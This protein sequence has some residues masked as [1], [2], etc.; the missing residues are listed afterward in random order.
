MQQNPIAATFEMLKTEYSVLDTKY[1]AA[2]TAWEKADTTYKTAAGNLD[3]LQGQYTET[4]N[5]YNQLKEKYDLAKEDFKTAAKPYEDALEAYKNAVTAQTTINDA[6]TEMNNVLDT[7]PTDQIT[8]DNLTGIPDALATW[9]ARYDAAKIKLANAY[10]DAW[11]VIETY[12]NLNKEY[13]KSGLIDL[14]QQISNVY[15]PSNFGQLF[16]D[17]INDAQA[18]MEENVKNAKTYQQYFIA[19]KAYLD[20]YETYMEKWAEGNEGDPANDLMLIWQP[21]INSLRKQDRNYNLLGYTNEQ[22]QSMFTVEEFEA[23]ILSYETKGA[24]AL[25]NINNYNTNYIVN[26]DTEWTAAQNQL[27]DEIT[28]F[29]N[30][31]GIKVNSFFDD[32]M[33][34]SNTTEMYNQLSIAYTTNVNYLKQTIERYKNYSGTVSVYTWIT[35]YNNNYLGF[36]GS[37][38][39]QPTPDLIVVPP[40]EL[41]TIKTKLNSLELSKVVAPEIAEPSEMLE[42]PV[43][44]AILSVPL[45][46]VP[47]VEPE[48]LSKEPTPV[49][50]K[51]LIGITDVEL[52][53]L[54]TKTPS[55]PLQPVEDIDG[56]ETITDIEKETEEA[57]ESTSPDAPLEIDDLEDVTGV[58]PL[59]KPKEMEKA[60]E[61]TAPSTPNLTA[62]ETVDEATKPVEKVIDLTDPTDPKMAEAPIASA[63]P[64]A[65]LSLVKPTEKPKDP[66]TTT[67]TT[68]RAVARTGATTLPN[69]RSQRKLPNTGTE[70]STSA[71]SMGVFMAGAAGSLLFWKR[72]K[73]KHEK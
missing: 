6:I 64:T 57:T 27:K 41:K 42:A 48:N 61:V 73:G 18:V 31:T 23:F 35:V 54:T 28:E 62:P 72:R 53:E 24:E 43:E 59:E 55:E 36:D 10:T 44:P 68:T 58:D 12:Q 14:S 16:S 67:V 22:L 63:A 5:A 60:P 38:G 19:Y 34:T 56:V 69:T 7:F 65:P 25:K 2:Y 46:V 26:V 1:I 21:T 30:A 70:T 66:V 9:Q 45:E 52:I 13:N 51:K 49:S 20:S 40:I 15:D 29:T 47:A 39:G 3:S 32:G 33:L 8:Q 4:L 37:V 17:F 11:P 50:T 71:Q